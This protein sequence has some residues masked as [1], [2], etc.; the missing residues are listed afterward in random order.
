MVASPKFDYKSAI[1]NS[2]YSEE[3]IVIALKTH[4]IDAI[5]P[6]PPKNM[7]T[8]WY[9]AHQIDVLIFPR[10]LALPL[11]V[12][13]RDIRFTCPQDFPFPELHAET[14]DGWKAKVDKPIAIAAISSYTQS[15][16]VA[17]A[18]EHS[19]GGIW[20]EKKGYD[21]ERQTRETWLACKKQGLIRFSDFVQKLKN[22][23]RSIHV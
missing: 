7:P 17:I 2:R 10:T 19:Q 22:L 18:P 3:A 15:V 21:P 13:V 14:V 20:F 16:V 11:E 4:D 12:K 1:A 8:S 6:V 5:A 9:T 23:E